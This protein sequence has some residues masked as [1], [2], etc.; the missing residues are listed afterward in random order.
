MDK[1]FLFKF[2]E[3]DFD[4]IKEK[5]IFFGAKFVK[6]CLINNL[7]IILDLFKKKVINLLCNCDEKLKFTIFSNKFKKL[8]TP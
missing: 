3:K 4:F 6:N 8:K 2:I 5:N 7:N 1:Q